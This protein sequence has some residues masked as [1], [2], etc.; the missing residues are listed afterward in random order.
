MHNATKQCFNIDKAELIFNNEK[1]QQIN[2]KTTPSSWVYCNTL[3]SWA[4]SK[5]LIE[6]YDSTLLSYNAKGTG[7]VSHT[8]EH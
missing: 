1:R 3:T 6:N 5:I 7:K 2:S 4:K 8:H